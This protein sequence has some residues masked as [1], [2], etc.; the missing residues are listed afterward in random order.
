MQGVNERT[1]S[2]QGTLAQCQQGVNEVARILLEDGSVQYENTSTNYGMAAAMM[3]GGMGGLGGGLG[4]GGMYGGMMGGGLGLDFNPLAGL[5]GHHG[6][7]QG[8]LGGMGGGDQFGGAGAITMK[9]AIAE[10]SG[11]P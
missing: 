7:Q 8:G 2:V 11:V 9:L 4:G 5:P 1:V 3:G 10:T 6:V